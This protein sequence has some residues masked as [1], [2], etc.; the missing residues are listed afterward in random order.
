M[1]AAQSTFTYKWIEILLLA[2]ISSIAYIPDEERGDYLIEHRKASDLLKDLAG[3]Q[4]KNPWHRDR[5]NLQL[6]LF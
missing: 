2:L 1:I 6:K 4:I 5:D 3:V